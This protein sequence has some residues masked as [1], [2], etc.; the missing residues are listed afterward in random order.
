MAETH[1]ER[2]R[3]LRYQLIQLHVQMAKVLAGLLEPIAIPAI[4]R[5][6]LFTQQV[7]DDLEFAYVAVNAQELDEQ[8]QLHLGEMIMDWRAAADYLNDEKR[9]AS[10][11][12]LDFAS[13]QATRVLT[14]VHIVREMLYGSP[15]D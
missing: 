6:G 4:K 10:T 5:K 3:R 13:L 8:I 9:R 2:R 15:D 12:N 1:D 14:T 7:L 11:I